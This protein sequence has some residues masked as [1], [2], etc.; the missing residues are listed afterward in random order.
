MKR[1]DALLLESEISP[2]IG[3]QQTLV[4]AR[5]VKKI[6]RQCLFESTNSMIK[7]FS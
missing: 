3:I 4:R 2:R 6:K 1:R 5:L 7:A